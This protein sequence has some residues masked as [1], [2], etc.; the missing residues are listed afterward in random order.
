[1]STKIRMRCSGS[2]A[3]EQQQYG[4]RASSSAGGA[5]SLRWALAASDRRGAG[6]ARCAGGVRQQ[7]Q[8]FAGRRHSASALGAGASDRR[9]AAFSS[10]GERSS[11]RS[12]R[13]PARSALRG[14]RRS[15]RCESRGAAP[16]GRRN[17]SATRLFGGSDS[18]CELFRGFSDARADRSGAGP[19]RSAVVHGGLVSRLGAAAVR[20]S[21][22][23][24]SNLAWR[25]G[26]RV[27]RGAALAWLRRTRSVGAACGDRSGGRTICPASFRLYIPAWHLS[28]E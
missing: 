12:V 27:H 22:A 19:S 20:R 9:G 23:V 14:P 11:H 18:G 15:V 3:P 1:M 7:A 28:C 21:A 16:G 6:R 10:A 4:V 25:G 24:V 2:H 8:S 17:P 13:S 26:V 5:T